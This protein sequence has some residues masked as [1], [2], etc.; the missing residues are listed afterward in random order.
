MVVNVYLLIQ[1]LTTGHHLKLYANI[2]KI[3]AFSYLVEISIRRTQHRLG[4]R[5]FMNWRRSMVVGHY[6]MLHYEIKEIEQVNRYPICDYSIDRQRMFRLRA[7]SMFRVCLWV[8]VPF[9]D[10]NVHIGV[11]YSLK[12]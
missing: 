4:W 2:S 10:L 6:V 5:F 11:L 9:G 7:A 8:W 12:F 3:I 1:K